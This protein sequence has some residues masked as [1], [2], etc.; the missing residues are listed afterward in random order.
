MRRTGRPSTRNELLPHL[1]CRER[2]QNAF[3]ISLICGSLSCLSSILLSVT[4]K[5]I[6]VCHV[7]RCLISLNALAEERKEEVCQRRCNWWWAGVSFV[8]VVFYLQCIKEI[9]LTAGI[10]KLQWE[11]DCL[12][13]SSFLCF[14]S[15]LRSSFLLFIKCLNSSLLLLLPCLL[16]SHLWWEDQRHKERKRGRR[17]VWETRKWGDSSAAFVHA[18]ICTCT[19]LHS[20]L[21]MY[22]H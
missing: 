17:A 8:E 6:S 3:L 5:S 7:E 19:S 20:C 10:Y 15:Y 21:C 9:W 4:R 1:A 11:R 22:L 18:L 16:H 14:V 12:N 2:G 13:N